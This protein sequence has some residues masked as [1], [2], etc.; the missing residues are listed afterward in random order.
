MTDRHHRTTGLTPGGQQAAAAAAAVPPG[1]PV[2]IIRELSRPEAL[3]LL[4]SVP[5]GR[6]V[7]SHHALP[8]IRP[9]NHILADGHVIIRVH[10]GA[11]LLGPARYGAVVA[12][13]VDELDPAERTGWSTVVTGFASLV[14]D[15]EEQR[16]YR[17]LLQP[18]IGR[19][20][21]H[22]VRIST[23]I[24]TGYRLG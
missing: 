3:G 20:T 14:Q 17:D 15:P 24:V 2:R 9:V 22:V 7:F 16:R 18:W 13:E 23:D 10:H 19:E 8:A 1:T 12:Y 5:M 11:A 6:V 21:E 4:G